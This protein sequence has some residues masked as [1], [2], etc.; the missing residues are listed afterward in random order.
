MPRVTPGMS[1]SMM[2]LKDGFGYFVRETCLLLTLTSTYFLK[3]NLG[4]APSLQTYTH[5]TYNVERKLERTKVIWSP[6]R[7][8]KVHGD[9]QFARL[10]VSSRRLTFRDVFILQ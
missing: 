7:R 2:A 4:L 3:H 9:H 10:T 6:W 1:K 5:V 8:L